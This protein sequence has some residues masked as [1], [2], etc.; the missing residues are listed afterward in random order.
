MTRGEVFGKFTKFTKTLANNAP[1][2]DCT[3]LCQCMQGHLNFRLSST[4]VVLNRIDNLDAT[5]ILRNTVNSSTIAKVTLREMLYCLKLEN[6]SPL[7]LQ[8]TKRPSGEVDAMIPNNPEAELKAERINQQLAAWCLNYWTESNPGSAAF[9][10][11]CANRAFNQALLH[12]VSKCTWDAATLMVTSPSSQSNIVAIAEFESQ[13][14]VQDILKAGT[15]STKQNAKAYVDPNIA[16]PFKDGFSVGT[17]HGANATK[18]PAVPLTETAAPDN[19]PTAENPSNQN[20]TIEILADDAED[21]VSVLTTK[22]QDE[23]VALMVKA[24]RQIHA[25]NGS[26]VASGSGIPPGSGLVATPSPSNKGCQ[27]TVPTNNAV[28]SA[29]GAAVD[30]EVRNMP[31][32]K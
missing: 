8:L 30:R 4:S 24:R 21:D 6:G 15:A 13:D 23:L 16:S 9:Y 31:S 17:I 29:N 18:L 5:E 20:A 32:G 1:L 10:R 3:K 7:F 28:S 2:S 11:Q 19:T 14:C 26:Q 12:E 27:Q 25:S 22:T